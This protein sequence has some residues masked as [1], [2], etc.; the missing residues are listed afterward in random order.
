MKISELTRESLLIP[1]LSGKTMDEVLREMVELL[2]ADGVVR[3]RAM[4]MRLV[5]EREG[6]CSTCLGSSV[7][8]PH[9]RSETIGRLTYVVGK[10][11][12]SLAFPDD[13]HKARL[14]FLIAIPQ[15]ATG[16]YLQV[17]SG[18]AGFL[19]DKDLRKELV[20]AETPKDMLRALKRMDRHLGQ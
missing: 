5:L 17:L 20:D 8:F 13:E 4:F 19:H 16:V 7:A 1:K 3:D 14:F 12:A 6:L 15:F 18:L 2:A 9:A 10:R 11:H